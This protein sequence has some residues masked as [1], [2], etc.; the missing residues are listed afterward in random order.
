MSKPK[1]KLRRWPPLKNFN[2]LEAMQAAGYKD[3]LARISQV[4][5]EYMTTSQA[6]ILELARSKVALESELRGY[7]AQQSKLLRE[8]AEVCAA[9]DEALSLI[10]T[11][12]G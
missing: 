2:T 3:L 1:C 11:Y 9:R 5:L 10:Y 7:R 4:L 8:L 12:R 6:A